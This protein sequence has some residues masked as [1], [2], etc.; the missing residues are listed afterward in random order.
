MAF[1][2]CKQF[3]EGNAT[4]IVDCPFTETFLGS[5]LGGLTG[6]FIALGIL[7][8]IILIAAFY[9]YHALAWV[10]IARKLKHKNP[11]LAW[12][13]FASSAMRLQLG[14]YHWAWIFLALVPILGWIILFVLIIIS[15]W[16]IF[17]KRNYP[18]WFSLAQ[19]IPKLGGILYLIII[20]YVAWA[21]RKKMLFK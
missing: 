18:G 6:F 16:R 9:I 13:P 17:K 15:H 2:T 21:D 3:F 8:A 5:F 11:W 14:G 19:L 1:E 20:G 10:T 7:I 4:A 12:I